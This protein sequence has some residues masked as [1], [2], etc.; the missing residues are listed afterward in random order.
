MLEDSGVWLRFRFSFVQFW[1]EDRICLLFAPPMLQDLD[2][3][4]EVLLDLHLP[5]GASNHKYTISFEAPDTSQALPSSINLFLYDVRENLDLRSPISGFDRQ[6]DGTAI[7]KRP[8][9]K[10]DCSYLI[11]A[12]PP[13]SD[14]TS[15]P[16]PAEEHRMLGEVMKVLLRYP[17]LPREVLQGS[18]KGQE[19][20]V[21]AFAL[22]SGQ[23]QS[24]GD[25]WQAMGGKPKAALNYT[26]TLP[27]A[28]DETLETVPLVLSQPAVVGG[29]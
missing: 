7:R 11:T 17:T 27:V 18:L 16:D 1:P 15:K 19:P 22:R 9:A 3:T 10:V 23:L 28:I 21:R 5:R 8:A 25:F 12:W 29:V 24:P 13:Q 6:Q 26:V 14:A 2:K 20:P 4:L